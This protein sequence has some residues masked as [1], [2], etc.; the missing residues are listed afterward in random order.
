[1]RAWRTHPSRAAQL[2]WPL[3]PP[4]RLGWPAHC[5][6]EDAAVLVVDEAGGAEAD[7]ALLAL[8]AIA[9]LHQAVLGLRE[10]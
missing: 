7:R 5:S 8:L 10:R 1:M 9:A 4:A 3:L 6:S 2:H